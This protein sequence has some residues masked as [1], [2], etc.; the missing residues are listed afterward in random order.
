MC[1]GMFF[2]VTRQCAAVKSS[3]LIWGRTK[4]TASSVAGL[5]SLA[6]MAFASAASSSGI[7]SSRS[8]T[9]ASPGSNNHTG[10]GGM[11]LLQLEVRGRVC[12]FAACRSSSSSSSVQGVRTDVAAV[13]A[14]VGERDPGCGELRRQARQA[15]ALQLRQRARV[16]RR[17]QP[18][19]PALQHALR[20]RDANEHQRQLHPFPV[21]HSWLPLSSGLCRWSQQEMSIRSPSLALPLSLE[22][23]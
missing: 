21:H 6:A 4:W 22:Q 9:N 8:R 2:L 20:H 19:A 11:R 23:H 17:V 10:F 12:G 15:R 5:V 7:T 3:K 13:L 1:A 14:V 16:R 18:A